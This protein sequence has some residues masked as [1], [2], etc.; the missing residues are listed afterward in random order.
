[1]WSR[2]AMLMNDATEIPG[3]AVKLSS[4]TLLICVFVVVLKLCFLVFF[5]DGVVLL[6]FCG[7]CPR[8]T[9]LSQWMGLSEARNRMSR[10]MS[11]RNRESRRI[12]GSGQFLSIVRGVTCTCD[13]WHSQLKQHARHHQPV[14]Q[15]QL[16]YT[17][18]YAIGTGCD[19]HRDADRHPRDCIR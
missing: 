8:A 2:F 10:R 19:R 13:V 1:M 4:F 16:N 15:K 11:S 9:L 3:G 12:M 18:R 7:V 17:T 5:V 14:S 6:L